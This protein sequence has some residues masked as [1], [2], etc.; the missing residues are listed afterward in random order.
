MPWWVWMLFC[1]LCAQ[2]GFALCALMGV[3]RDADTTARLLHKLEQMDSK[4]EELRLRLAG[5]K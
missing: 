1:L 5:R 4:M 2:G 3:G